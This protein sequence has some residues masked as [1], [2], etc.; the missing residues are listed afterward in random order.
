MMFM[1]SKDPEYRPRFD[2]LRV[3]C[4]R[5]ACSFACRSYVTVI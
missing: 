2:G 4:H 1:K 3:R 5:R